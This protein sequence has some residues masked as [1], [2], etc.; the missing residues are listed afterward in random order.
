MSQKHIQLVLSGGAATVSEPVNPL[1][2][3]LMI[4]CSYP[5]PPPHLKDSLFAGFL[6][7][8]KSGVTVSR[9][10]KLPHLLI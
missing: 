10:L 5:P 2:L 9:R 6:L 3:E 1:F 7:V 4:F 8:A